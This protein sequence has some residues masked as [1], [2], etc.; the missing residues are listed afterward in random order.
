[1]A[2]TVVLLSSFLTACF[3]KYVM[4]YEFDWN[5]SLLLGV[6]LSA[7]DHVAVVSMLKEI[8]ANDRFETLLGGETLLNEATI[9][10]F[11]NLCLDS[12]IGKIDIS[13]RFVYF[14]QLTLGGLGIGFGFSL[15]LAWSLKRIVND[16]NQEVNLTV[17]SAYLLFFLADHKAKCSGALA[18]VTLGLFMSAYGKTLISPLVE[19]GMHDFWNIAS[20]NIESIVF[21]LAGMLF[22]MQIVDSNNIGSKEI[23][24]LIFLFIMLHFVRGLVIWVHFPI[25][26]RLGYGLTI[27]EAL[28]MTLA[29]LKGVISTALALIAYHETNLDSKYRDI[30]LFFT[31]GIAFLTIVLDS[32]AVK[33][34]VRKFGMDTLNEV[35]ENMMLGVTTAVLHHT[36]KKVEHIRALKE[37]NLVKWDEVMKIAGPK[38][39][40]HSVMKQTKVG[41]KL[42]KKH[43]KDA[44]EELMRRYVKKFNLTTSMLTTETRRRFYTTLK[45]IYWHEFEAGQCLG[46]TALMLI[47]SCNRCLDLEDSSMSD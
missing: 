3:I 27:K 43:P 26:K 19:K 41:S 1:M 14:F 16:M 22:G 38:C 30:L 11:F 36:A 15:A 40:L 29:G 17:V 9:L 10:V 46:Y 42:L 32:F 34:F 24:M 7:T 18:V 28:I 4:D 6:I 2:T 5:E 39:L 44:P 20:T 13:E 23:S 25:L 35:Q 12:A 33:F 21:I 37:F 45:G 47:N 31:I 8:R